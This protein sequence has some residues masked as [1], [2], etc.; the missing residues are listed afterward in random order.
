MT[1]SSDSQ[2]SPI[3]LCKDWN[4]DSPVIYMGTF[5]KTIYPALRIG[6][7]VVPKKLFSPLRIVAS[8]L[9]RGGHLLDQ[10]VGRVYP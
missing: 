8:E 2:V 4:P 10:S 6:Y 1:V 9:Y 7:L 5:S 3:R